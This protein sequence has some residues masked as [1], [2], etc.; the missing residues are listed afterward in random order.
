MPFGSAASEGSGG[1]NVTHFALIRMR[2]NGAGTLHMYVFS[3]DDVRYKVM[4]PFKLLERNRIL[5]AR[6]VNFKEQ[7]ACFEIKTS[8]TNEFFRINRIIIFAAESD[9]SHYGA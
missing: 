2:V 8:G 6:I 5:P 3:L 4:A 9:T 1:D 7:R